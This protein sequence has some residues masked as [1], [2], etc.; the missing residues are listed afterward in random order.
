MFWRDPGPFHVMLAMREFL[1]GFTVEPLAVE[2][3]SNTIPVGVYPHVDELFERAWK[4][5]KAAE[6]EPPPLED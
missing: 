6:G 3:D 1:E 5:R 4:I 2:H